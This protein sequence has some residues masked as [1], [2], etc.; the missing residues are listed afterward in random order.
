[1]G[2]DI[3]NFRMLERHTEIKAICQPLFK[4]FNLQ[5]FRFLRVYPNG[6]R[7]NLCSDPDWTINY[8][9]KGL[10]NVAWFDSNPQLITH[11]FEVIWDERAVNHDNRVGVEARTKYNIFHGV[12]FVRPGMYYYELYDF[13]TYDEEN[14][15][16]NEHYRSNIRLFEHFILYFKD[17]ASEI[18]KFAAQEKIAPPEPLLAISP[19]AP[20]IQT[21]K[22]HYSA[23][24]FLVD[25]QVKRYYLNEIYLT[26]RELECI[27]WLAQGKSAEEIALLLG[28]TQRTIDTHLENI[29][30]KLNCSKMSQI[31]KIVTA[32]GLLTRFVP[33]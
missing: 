9:L 32:A 33:Q 16:V 27:Y 1:M 11:N 10:Y 30:K 26:Q 18:I 17:Q 5:F 23:E 19:A 31:I 6:T 20:L 15:N 14:N 21:D 29:R 12:T 22:H 28:R 25:T 2:L 4:L 8:Y 24:R 3:S 13:A 7:I